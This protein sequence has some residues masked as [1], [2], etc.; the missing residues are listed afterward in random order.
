MAYK[1][2][3]VPLLCS[4]GT[5]CFRKNERRE[6]KK[7]FAVAPHPEGPSERRGSDRTGGGRCYGVYDSR[8]C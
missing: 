7:R 5:A 2:E 3:E 1:N 8:Q 6:L 4:P